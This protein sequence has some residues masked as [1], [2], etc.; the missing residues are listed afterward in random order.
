MRSAVT[1]RAGGGAAAVAAAA[2]ARLVSGVVVAARQL[3]RCG[4]G[5]R[6]GGDPVAWAVPRLRVAEHQCQPRRGWPRTG[7]APADGGSRGGR[8]AGGGRR[9]R[10]GGDP[11]RRSMSVVVGLADVY[12]AA[13]AVALGMLPARPALLR[14]RAAQRARHGD[15]GGWV[16][17]LDGCG[18]TERRGGR[19]GCRA[20]GWRRASNG[21]VGEGCRTEGSGEAAAVLRASVGLSVAVLG[22]LSRRADCVTHT[23]RQVKTLSR[24]ETWQPSQ[25]PFNLP[26]KP[27]PRPKAHP[28][29]C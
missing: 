19:T 14:R 3:A 18:A 25:Q 24:C 5:K 2:S 28:P 21:E 15:Q 17:R 12:M 7:A 23:R 16:A 29:E 26:V 9:R 1:D 4:A 6:V 13:R 27:S 10:V 20:G 8:R 22:R 11:L